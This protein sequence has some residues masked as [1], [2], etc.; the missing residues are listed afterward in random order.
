MPEEIIYKETNFIKNKIFHIRGVSVMLDTDLAELYHVETKVLNQAVKRNL[1]RFPEMFL[2]R[3][4]EN[5]WHSLRSQIVTLKGQRGQ[6]RKYLPLV[7]TEQGV[8]MLAAVLKSDIAVKVSIQIMNAFVLM[9]KS[10]MHLGLF[11][12]RL[13]TLEIKQQKNEL[14]FDKIFTALEKA[15]PIPSQGI[16]FN[17]QIFDAYKFVSDIIRSAKQ[18]IILIDNYID[19]NTLALLSKRDKNVEAI[20]FT[21][22][23][24][25]LINDIQKHDQQYPPISFHQLKDNHDRF[26]IIDRKEMYHIG[27]S[28][29][30][31]GKKLFAFSRMD[32]ETKRLME[33]LVV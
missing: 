24:S 14:T 15:D 13:K 6:H 29:K 12:K 30:D 22:K 8:A 2:F 19:E 25:Q 9:R 20:I 5:D 18:S 4:D 3:L 27:A 11:Q 16:F 21:E 7:F 32:A 31:L 33:V 1:G 10:G 28:L 26:I 23:N 17:G